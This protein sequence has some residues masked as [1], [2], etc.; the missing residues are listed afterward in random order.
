MLNDVDIE[1]LPLKDTTGSQVPS[2]YEM[3]ALVPSSLPPSYTGFC[4]CG[5]FQ[6]IVHCPTTLEDNTRIGS[7]NC[8]ICTRNGSVNLYRPLENYEWVKGKLEDLKRYE[9]GPVSI[10]SKR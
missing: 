9:F 1:A 2:S 3:E 4:H 5:D 10:C 7:C 8:S 6:Y